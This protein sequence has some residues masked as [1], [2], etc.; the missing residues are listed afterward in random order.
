MFLA[1]VK[2][3]PADGRTDMKKIIAAFLSFAKEPKNG[4]TFLGTGRKEL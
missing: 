4:T 2:L 3:F 1:G